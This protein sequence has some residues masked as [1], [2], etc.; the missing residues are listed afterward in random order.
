MMITLP[1]KFIELRINK[2]VQPQYLYS[3]S[4]SGVEKDF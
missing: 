2:A 4:T 3:R 1:D